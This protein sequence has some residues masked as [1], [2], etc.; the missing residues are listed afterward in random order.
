MKKKIKQQTSSKK[1]TLRKRVQPFNGVLPSWIYFLFDKAYTLYQTT[2][3]IGRRWPKRNLLINFSPGLFDGTTAS[4][5]L[6]L[7][8]LLLSFVCF[9]GALFFTFNGSWCM[10]DSCAELWVVVVAADVWEGTM[11][12]FVRWWGAPHS[13]LSPSPIHCHEG[14]IKRG[15]HLWERESLGVSFILCFL[16]W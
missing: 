4:K 11:P 14:Q 16:W 6:P 13:S 2:I 15:W 7:R 12:A 9:S 10:A 5:R 3:D 1:K 8:L